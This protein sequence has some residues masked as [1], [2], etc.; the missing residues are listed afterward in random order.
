MKRPLPWILFA[1]LAFYVWQAAGPW[2]DKVWNVKHGRDFASFY[3]AAR[4]AH[5]QGDPYAYRALSKLAQKEK[6]RKG[7]VHPFFYPPPFLLSFLWV[8]PL[9]FVTAYRIWYVADHLFLLIIALALWRW[10]PSPAMAGGLAVMAATYSPIPDNDWM[11]QVNLLVLACVVPGLLLAERGH[12]RW[13]GALVGLA[14]MLKM[15]P[16]LLVAWWLLHRRWNAVGAAVAAGLGLSLLA[17][18]LAD[19]ELQWRFY[20]EVLPGFGQGSYHGLTVP[21]D[22]PHNH[23]IPSLLHEILG[24]GTKTSLGPLARGISRLVGL[25]LLGGLAWRFRRR[26]GDPTSALCQAG[27]V[28]VLM[29]VL[30]VYSYEHHM[31]W[32]ILP[33][34]AAA[35]ALASGRLGRRWWWVLVSCYLVQALPLDWL[36]EIYKGLDALGSLRQPVYYALRESKFIAALI[37]GLACL[38]AAGRPGAVPPRED[39]VG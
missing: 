5:E 17:L 24:G 3:Y 22:L 37:T 32:M 20:T 7:S 12:E 26:P 9:D 33:Y 35:A 13:G 19:A 4:V 14:C 30:P 10:R 16:A 29:L 18:P 1:C 15:S 11:G 25:L 2:K 23:S 28:V 38:L 31:V 36:K 21:I 27:A 34:A 6:T 8:L 39:P